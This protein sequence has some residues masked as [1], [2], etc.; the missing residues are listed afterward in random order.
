M[1]SDV[2]D[3][4]L[5]AGMVKVAVRADVGEV[6]YGALGDSDVSDHD[7]LDTLVPED[8]ELEKLILFLEDRFDV[9]LGDKVM[10]RLFAD[11]TVGE[12]IDALVAALPGKTAAYSHHRYMLKREQ[13]KARARSYRMTNAVALR[14][15]AKV[16]RRKVARGLVRP[17]RRVGSAGSGYQFLV[18]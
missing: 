8:G 18:R 2:F 4:A 3:A 16:Y 7:D 9:R 13:H 1:R 12:L 10:Y 14:R 11:G 15:R 17:R 5:V 6:V